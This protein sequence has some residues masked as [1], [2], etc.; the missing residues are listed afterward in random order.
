MWTSVSARA[1]WAFGS[2]ITAFTLPFG[3]FLLRNYMAGIPREI[4]ENAKLDGATDLQIF[5]RIVL[6]LSI[7]ALVA[8]AIIQFLWTFNDLLAAKVFLI[9]RLR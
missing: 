9:G 7:P 2:S 4:I 1:I 3:I 6:P 8:W 5:V